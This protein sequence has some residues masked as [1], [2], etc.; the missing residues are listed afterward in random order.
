MQ[1]RAAGIAWY[2]QQD[3][4]KIRKIMADPRNFPETYKQ[5]L[6]CAKKASDKLIAEGYTVEKAYIDPATF[7]GWCNIRSL[8]VD[9]KARARFA[10]EIVSGKHFH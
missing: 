1:N 7:L 3:Y 4:A 10:N 5:W 2:R 9:A 8:D 6:K